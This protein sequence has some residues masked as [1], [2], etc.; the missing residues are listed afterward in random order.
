[1]F[2]EKIRPYK[3]DFHGDVRTLVTGLSYQCPD[4]WESILESLDSQCDITLLKEPNNPHDEFSIAAYLGDRKIGYVSKDDN[5]AITMFIGNEP[6]KCD[7]IEKYKASFK[8]SFEHPQK[9][10]EGFTPEQ[11]F[12]LQSDCEYKGYDKELPSYE[13]PILEIDNNHY[14][15]YDDRIVLPNMEKWIVDFNRKFVSNKIEL[16]CRQ[17][18]DG[19]FY[20][21]LP[22]FNWNVAEVRSQEICEE[23]KRL[24]IGIGLVDVATITYQH[25]I[26][27]DLKVAL[28][29][30]YSGISAM[31]YFGLK[32]ESKEFNFVY[33]PPKETN[34]ISISEEV[35][36]N[37]IN[38]SL[39]CDV[40]NSPNSSW[41]YD[42][43][44]F[45]GDGRETFETY[46]FK[47]RILDNPKCQE[48]KAVVPKGDKVN[49]VLDIKMN[50]KEIFEFVHRYKNLFY[51]DYT[52]AK[53]KKEY[54]KEDFSFFTE[55]ISPILAVS[56]PSM[57]NPS[58]ITFY[59][60]FCNKA[61]IE[62]QKA[63][64]KILTL[65]N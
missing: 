20:Y 65:R 28:R 25:T 35:F 13:I 14:D 48:I 60:S 1:M 63:K 2:I 34:V 11:I 10:Y 61:Y 21:Y 44:D 22:Y 17:A 43:T 38:E 42:T 57:G 36:A 7:V 24:G 15:W 45:L 46:M 26:V 39:G 58:S 55:G 9:L 6:V 3:V 32:R 12:E 54:G 49:F 40:L 18:S 50:K 19:K 56:F 31:S 37:F 23:L 33:E 30:D 27:A 29:K 47:K 59:T 51:P 4:D 41:K 64:G 62:R 16:V 52:L 8:V 53:C 5:T